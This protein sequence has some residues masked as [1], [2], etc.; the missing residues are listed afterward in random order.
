[1][2]KYVFIVSIPY[3][4]NEKRAIERSSQTPPSTWKTKNCEIE[5]VNQHQIQIF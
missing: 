1:M 4:D 2:N 5:T 3:V